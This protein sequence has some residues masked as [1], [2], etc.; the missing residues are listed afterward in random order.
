[1]KTLNRTHQYCGL[2]RRKS[3][4][5]WEPAEASDIHMA[6]HAEYDSGCVEFDCVS[7]VLYNISVKIKNPFLIPDCIKLDLC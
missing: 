7:Q 5:I 4:A 2:I 1:M 6:R 3:Q